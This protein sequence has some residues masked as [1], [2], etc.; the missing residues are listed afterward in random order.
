M[1][2]I[3]LIGVLFGLFSI[4]ICILLI[5]KKKTNCYRKF[6][7]NASSTNVYKWTSLSGYSWAQF[8]VLAHK[9][10][11]NPIQYCPGWSCS[12]PNK[13]CSAG[14]GYVCQPYQ[15]LTQATKN[16]LTGGAT[17]CSD[18]RS[19]SA[20]FNWWVSLS[21]YNS[22][23]KQKLSGAYG[24]KPIDKCPG[25]ICSTL[26]TI[27][28]YGSGYICQTQQNKLD[29]K[30]KQIL[31]STTPKL[32]PIGVKD[33][34]KNNPSCVKDDLKFLCDPTVTTSNVSGCDLQNDWECCRKKRTCCK[35]EFLSEE[36]KQD[37][38]Q[39]SSYPNYNHNKI[40]GVYLKRTP[41]KEKPTSVFADIFSNCQA[42][43]NI[44]VIGDE[45]IDIRNIR[46]D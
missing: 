34:E 7:Q 23:Q 15:T 45:K 1:N 28:S 12:V 40:G 44:K 25:N 26:N 17:E 20:C 33:T 6:N 41:N 43:E 10:K 30:T 14:P 13:M 39:Y 11:E 36:C 9:T 27:C 21:G 29:P 16:D 8:N 42:P 3:I 19:N 18:D 24:T 46:G 32:Q 38:H 2:F 31:N 35:K 4:L 37:M 5:L 22:E